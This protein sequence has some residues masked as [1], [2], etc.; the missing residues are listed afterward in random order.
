M[1]A[2][3]K[4]ETQR[5]RDVISRTVREKGRE[6]GERGE[7]GERCGSGGRGAGE[8]EENERER[9]RENAHHLLIP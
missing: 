4:R 6:R 5:T 3:T 8:R 7:G 1:Q 9:E 2:Y